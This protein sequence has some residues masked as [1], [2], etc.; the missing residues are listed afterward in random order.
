MFRRPIWQPSRG[1]RIEQKRLG[2]TRLD[3]KAGP[4]TSMHTKCV[5]LTS[6][7]SSLWPLTAINCHT[8]LHWASSCN[9][10][11]SDANR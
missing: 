7:T 2:T 6:F 10:H 5:R 8:D 3:G 9:S 11:E 4:E 1:L